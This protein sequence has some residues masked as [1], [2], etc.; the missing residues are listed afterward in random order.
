VLWLPFNNWNGVNNV[1]DATGNGNDGILFGS[2]ANRPVLVAGPNPSTK[3]ASISDNQFFG[4]TNWSGIETLPTGSIAVWATYRGT[5]YGNSLILDAGYDGVP[6]S[7][8][9]GRVDGN[10]N[11]MFTLYDPLTGVRIYKVTFPDT[12]PDTLNWN[13]YAVTWDGSTIVGYWNGNAFAT[14]TQTL[15]Y[16]KIGSLNHWMAIGT[17]H[18][19]GTP[20]IGDDA[21]PNCCYLNGNVADIRIYNRALTSAQIRAVYTGHAFPGPFQLR[22]VPIG[23]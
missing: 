10:V 14:N 18:H 16:L 21:Y 13:H 15:P 6:N 4:V 2:A 12:G 11:T 7:W 19:Q 22:V 3:G 9:F 5:S 20:Q 8:R 1:V 23:P 17:M